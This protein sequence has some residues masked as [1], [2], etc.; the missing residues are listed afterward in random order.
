MGI[1]ALQ[2][3]IGPLR[4]FEALRGLIKPLSAFERPFKEFLKASPIDLEIHKERAFP[5]YSE[6]L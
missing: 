5:I 2:G 6:N 1:R 4:A 3:L